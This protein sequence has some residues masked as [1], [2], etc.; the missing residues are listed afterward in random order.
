MEKNEDAGV[1]RID[2]HNTPD[3]Y[4][5]Y[6]RNWLSH[7]E[8]QRRKNPAELAIVKDLAALVEVAVGQLSPVAS[9][10][11]EGHGG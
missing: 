10:Q 3:F 11:E 4:L 7:E 1:K 8:K 6:M 5:A 9:A 2:L